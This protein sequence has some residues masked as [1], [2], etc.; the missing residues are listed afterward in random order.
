MPVFMYN[1]KKREKEVL[2]GRLFLLITD[3]Y[4]Q[5]QK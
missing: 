3:V 4:F 5:S 1:E 2:L